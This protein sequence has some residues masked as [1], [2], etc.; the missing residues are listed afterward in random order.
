MPILIKQGILS[1]RSWKKIGIIG[2]PRGI[3]PNPLAIIDSVEEGA[4]APKKRT[5]S[6]KDKGK[7]V[8]TPSLLQ[9]SPKDEGRSTSPYKMRSQL[10]VPMLKDFTKKRRLV[11]Q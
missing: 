9:P 11:L 3:K 10:Q 5:P 2:Q 1:H 6:Q 4:L 8:R 7:G